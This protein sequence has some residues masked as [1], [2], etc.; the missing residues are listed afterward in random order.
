MIELNKIARDLQTF[1]ESMLLPI[2]FNEDIELDKII[3]LCED[4]REKNI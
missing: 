2:D 1:Y 4:I 3:S